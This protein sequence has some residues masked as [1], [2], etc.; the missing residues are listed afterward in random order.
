MLKKILYCCVLLFFLFIHIPV[1]ATGVPLTLGYQGRIT[2]SSGSLLGGSGTTYYFKFSI[3]DNAT[4]GS[5]N[6][7]WP[8]SAPATT[9][10]LVRQGVF[11]V[12]IGDTVA[13]YPDALNYDFNTNSTIYLQVE[14]SAN[15]SS[16]ETLSPRQKISSSAFA[17]IAGKVSGIGQSTFGTTTPSSGAIVT[18]EATT[19]SA[20][21]ALIR[22]SSGQLADLFK[23]VNSSLSHL[24]SI[25]YS[26]GIF[27][28]STLLIGSS[29][30]TS[31]I[32]DSSGNVGIGT[33]TASRKLNV[34][35]ANSNPQ[36]R[37]GQS[38]SVYGEFYTDASGDVRI[39]TTGGNVRQNNENLWVCSEGGCGVDTPADKGNVIVE[40]SVI[41]NNKFK[42]KQ[43]NASTT[44]MYDT[45]NTSIL[46]FDE[47]Q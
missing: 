5:G 42:L 33:T 8:T 9:T 45:M 28:S 41:F 47:G 25:N 24:F 15:N 11:N 20:I 10:A 12:N 14:V 35:N 44:I 36:L 18:I 16:S 4:V 17:Q 31:F 22:A 27:A 37:L 3:W 30:A 38:G 7:L 2:D 32:V 6:R 43:I 13:G 39:S 26:G 23:I 21:P 1:N 40:T 19:T 46:E 34:L 29:D